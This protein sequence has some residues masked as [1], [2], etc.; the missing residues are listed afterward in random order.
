[1]KKLNRRLFLILFALICMVGVTVSAETQTLA[2]SM[3]IHPPTT[4]HCSADALLWQNHIDITNL[5]GSNGIPASDVRFIRGQITQYSLPITLPSEFSSGVDINISE[6]VAWDGYTTRPSTGDQPDERFKVVFLKNGSIAWESDWTG[7]TNN[8][9]IDTGALSDEWLGALGSGSL[10]DGAD[11]ILLVHYSDSQYGT[12]SGGANSVVPS[13][14]CIHYTPIEPITPPPAPNCPAGALLWQNHIDLNNLSGS[15][16]I[17]ATDVRFVGSNITQFTI[18]GPL[19]AEFSGDVSINILEAVSWDGYLTRATTGNQPDER[20]KVVFLKDGAVAYES[21]WTGVSD[22]DDGIST[23]LISDEWVGALGSGSLP[24]GADEILLVHWGD[25]E[26][27][28]NST[29]ANSVVPSSVCIEYQ[30]NNNV[31]AIGNYIWVEE[32][33]N[34]IFDSGSPDESGI[35]GVTVVLWEDTDNDNVPDTV[36]D[37]TESDSNGFYLF[38]ELPEGTYIVQIPASEF[39]V[40]EPLFQHFSSTGNGTN[41]PDPDDDVDGDDNGNSAGTLGTISNAVTIEFGNEPTGEGDGGLTPIAPDENSNLTV[42][43]GFFV[44]SDRVMV[45]G[46]VWVDGNSNGLMESGEQKMSGVTA[47]LF[48]ASG[49]TPA[50]YTDGSIVQPAVSDS[51][52]D[53]GWH[54]LPEGEY[55][56]MIDHVAGYELSPLGGSDADLN[57]SDTDNNGNPCSD[58]HMTCQ[59]AM[60]EPVMVTHGMEPLVDGQTAGNDADGNM[61]L[62]FGLEVVVPTAV[63]VAESGARTVSYSLVVMVI[64]NAL[65]A[66]TLYLYKEARSK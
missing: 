52:G 23:G 5:S 36:V 60:T 1:M 35:A 41:A 25:S 18:P 38:D 13:S 57:A 43:F 24:N 40:N 33:N 50:T 64:L 2:K 15:S 3:K 39:V 28:N 9:G 26:Y 51:V 30:A 17:P 59:F 19:P 45:G 31:G 53:F 63:T 46:T 10:P 14:V 61:T 12:N 4:P 54:D 49:M 48:D 27:G 32:D 66:C 34:G 55:V 44:I 58:R 21:S 8:D 16:G 20:Y 62:G 6:A 22:T 37:S 42:D 7:N 47:R 11:E 56:V 65:V 29:S